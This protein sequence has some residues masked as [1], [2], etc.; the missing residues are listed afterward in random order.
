M[1]QEQDP[2]QVFLPPRVQ[3]PK[4]KGE[5]RIQCVDLEVLRWIEVKITRFEVGVKREGRGVILGFVSWL[6]SE[7]MSPRPYL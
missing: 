7:E 4:S 2:N 6:W 1:E 3:N 5:S